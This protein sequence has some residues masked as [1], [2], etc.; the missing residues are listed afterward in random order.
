M[1]TLYE[2]DPLYY[3]AVSVEQPNQEG[4]IESFS[5]DG[6]FRNLEQPR[7]KE[8][9]REVVERSKA[10]GDGD[11]SEEGLTDETLAAELLGGWRGIVDPTGAEIPYSEDAK[12]K[13]LRK[14][15][16]AGAIVVAWFESITKKEEDRAGN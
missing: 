4:V 13:L 2:E 7:I 15:G 3:C 5:F 12:D 11:T 16:V 8:I 9:M 14:R 10:I 6:G 1:F